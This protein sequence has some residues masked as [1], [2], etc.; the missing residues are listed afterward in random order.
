MAGIPASYGFFIRTIA[1]F[2][3]SPMCA[4]LAANLYLFCAALGCG[5]K[6]QS[7][8]RRNVFVFQSKLRLNM[9][10]VKLK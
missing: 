7:S 4:A 9:T 1:L 10:S 5:C 2:L 3:K 6:Q 8:Q